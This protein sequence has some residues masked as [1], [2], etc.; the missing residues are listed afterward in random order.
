MEPFRDGVATV[1]RVIQQM[2]AEQMA[3]LQATAPQFV[4][5]P[6]RDALLQ[7]I[8]GGIVAAGRIVCLQAFPQHGQVYDLPDGVQ[9]WTEK[10]G[11]AP[12]AEAQE[13]LPGATRDGAVEGSGRAQVTIASSTISGVT[14]QEATNRILYA[15]Q[16]A[17]LAGYF[18]AQ[19]ARYG[20]VRLPMLSG[21]NPA[22]LP[23]LNAR[24]FT[25]EMKDEESGEKKRYWLP[26]THR[27]RVERLRSIQ[28]SGQV[29]E[30]IT[31]LLAAHQTAYDYANNQINLRDE[32]RQR[33]PIRAH[34]SIQDR[35]LLSYLERKWSTEAANETLALQQ[36][37][38]AAQQAQS[39]QLLNVLVEERRADREAT[40]ESAAATRELAAALLANK[41]ET[42]AP[43][44]AKVKK[45]S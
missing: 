2:Q 12:V 14:A 39:S 13:F 21:F 34:V 45:T 6:F 44:S 43:V 15:A 37:A 40:R 4:F 5:S 25:S 8:P 17:T 42:P 28:A 35:L 20:G 11:G 3:S 19:E 16:P 41:G 36:Q 31:A 23:A 24:L 30:L 32:E 7:D 26:L 33:N 27:A 1:P 22:E 10:G 29:K 18:A 38:Q 9:R